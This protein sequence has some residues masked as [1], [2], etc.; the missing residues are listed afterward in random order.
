MKVGMMMRG[1]RVHPPTGLDRVRD[2]MG[3]HEKV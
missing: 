3:G 2:G 1:S